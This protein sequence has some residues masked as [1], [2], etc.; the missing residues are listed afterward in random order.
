MQINLGAGTASYQLTNLPLGDYTTI[1]NALSNGAA[2][3]A[4]VSFNIQWSGVN[5]RVRV[6]DTVNGFAGE[7]VENTSNIAWSATEAGFTFVSDPA[8]TSTSKFA[9]IGQEHNGVFFP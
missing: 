5:R 4:T 7:F 6:R 3:A 9:V 8:S 2:V 1:G